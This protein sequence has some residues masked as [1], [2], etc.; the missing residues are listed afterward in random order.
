[1]LGGGL[2]ECVKSPQEAAADQAAA[3]KQREINYKDSFNR[4]PNIP[5][6]CVGDDCSHIRKIQHWDANGDMT[7]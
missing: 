1:M 2:Y 4:M 5:G 6:I 3:E 7:N